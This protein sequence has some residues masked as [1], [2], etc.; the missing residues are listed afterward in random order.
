MSK[1]QKLTPQQVR[2][3][4]K[5]AYKIPEDLMRAYRLASRDADRKARRIQRQCQHKNTVETGYSTLDDRD[6]LRRVYRCKDC[7]AEVLRD[8]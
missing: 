6:E 7:D 3:A 5:D 2:K 4:I 8:E 1:A